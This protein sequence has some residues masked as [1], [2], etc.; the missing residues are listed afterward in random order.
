[1]TPLRRMGRIIA[2]TTTTAL[3]LGLAPTALAQTTVEFSVSNITDFHGRMLQDDG[4]NQEMGAAL[5]AGLNDEINGAENV[6]TTSGDNVG[7]T[8]FV[9]AI[10]GDEY[11]IDFLNE[12]GVDVSAVGNHE[13]DKGQDDLLERIIPRSDFPVLGANVYRA[14]GTRL[15]DAYQVQERNG[16]RIAFVGTVTAATA[17]K[18]SPGGIAGLEFRDPVAETNQVAQELRDSGEADVV[19]ALMHEDARAH[20]GGFD[21]AAVDFVFGGDSHQAYVDNSGAV[22]YAQS[23]EYG[24]LLTD[25]DFTF[26]PTTKQIESVQ[27]EQY[28]LARAQEMGITP[29]PAVAGIVAQARAAADVVGGEVVA[30]T[31]HSFYRGAV[32]GGEPGSD[33]GV[34]ST[35]NHLIAEAQRASLAAFLEE[36][37][38]IGFMN[39]G[40]VRADMAAGQ[41]T[42]A[43]VNTVQPFGN[44]VSV[45]TISGRAILDTLERQW[46]DNPDAEHPR[47]ALGLSDGFSY[48]FDPTAPRMQK[49]IGATLNGE[50]LDPDRDY[51]I[52]ASTFLFEGGDNLFDPAELRDVLNVGYI[53][54]QAFIDYLEA[55]EDVAP[56][57]EPGDIGVVVDGELA[58]GQTVSVELSSLNYSNPTEPQADTAT[59]TL[60]DTVVSAPI[61]NGTATVELIVPAG[62]WSVADLSVTT[63]AQLPAVGPAPLAPRG[64]AELVG[65]SL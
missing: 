17:A 6:F 4:R 19:I 53:D 43:D 25:V 52:A 47:L 5:L 29:N 51:R 48:L 38:H 27:I 58:P 50:P 13:F 16:V 26:N 9:S 49:V 11:T 41:V 35:L 37:V 10:T 54:V 18:V 44:E 7:G 22:P 60:G 39:A 21:A 42:Y 24:K 12:A 55:N 57:V 3:A 64:S 28:N 65:S 2:A 8:A 62:T 34:E 63:N 46:Q 45:A 59:V 33:R 20:I 14:D 31:A 32:P 36:E 15:L 40:G 30:E 1:V 23:G 61:D 56:R